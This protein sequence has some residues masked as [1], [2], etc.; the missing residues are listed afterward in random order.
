M[1]RVYAKPVLAIQTFAM[2]Q[3]ITADCGN[4]TIPQSQLTL[5]EPSSCVW[6]LGGG[7]TVFISTSNCRIEGRTMEFLC[8]NNPTSDDRIFRAS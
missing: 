1:K 8:Y 3:S 7:Q 5:G 2:S 6:D 4:T